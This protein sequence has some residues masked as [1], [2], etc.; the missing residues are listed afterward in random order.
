[1]YQKLAK[2]DSMFL[3]HSVGNNV[4]DLFLNN[5]FREFYNLNGLTDVFLTCD[6]DWAP[7]YAVEAVLKAV[8]DTGHKLTMFATH[9]SQVLMNPPE[10]LEIGIHPDFTRPHS[11]HWFDEKLSTLK[12]MYP[13]AV[14]MRSHRNFFG[15]NIGDFAKA[16]G[17]S[18]DASVFLWNEPFCQAHMDYNGITRFSYMW[19][20]GIHLDMKLN[21]DFSKIHLA[22]PGLKILNVHPIL[23]Y[24]NAASEDHRRSVTNRYKDLTIAP[25]EEIIKEVNQNA[26]GIGSLW[27]DLLEYLA[28]NGI[29]THCLR[30]AI[31]V[32][33]RYHAQVELE[34][35][36]N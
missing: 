32:S 20:D 26:R 21:L 22:S 16:A 18:Y 24:L 12:A 2:E 17:L 13:D 10:W 7:D 23:I 14:G 3:D 35:C 8:E 1:M 4:N 11:T 5:P 36:V 34:A 9:Q 25:Y 29:R 19:E 6:V 33:K 31:E 15:Q 28:E 27:R 30:D